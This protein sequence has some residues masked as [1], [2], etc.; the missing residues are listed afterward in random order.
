MTRVFGNDAVKFFSYVTRLDDRLLR[1]RY[2]FYT[3]Q[4]S[5][6][7]AGNT[8]CVFV[9]FCEVVGHARRARM[10]IPPAQ[11]FR[12][13]HFTRRSLHQ[14]RPPQENR[15][16]ILD[17]DGFIAH[18]RHVCT[19]CR[20]RAHDARDLWNSLGAQVRLVVEDAAKVFLVRKH[21]ILQGQES[22]AR[23][24]QINAGQVVLQ[25]H[26]LRA[27]VFFYRHRVI[28]AALYGGIVGDNHTFQTLDAADACDHAGGGGVSWVALILSCVL[29]I[30]SPSS[31]WRKLE[32]R[33]A[34]VEKRLYPIAWQQ[35]AA[36]D[37]F[38]V[39]LFA[40][41]FSDSCRVC[42]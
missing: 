6:D 35:L 12:G 28:G 32:E 13:H 36:C 26:F 33:R 9:I 19:A 17:D 3:V 22:T 30:H 27:Q 24:D 38:G 8:E 23:I 14:R 37:V 10:Y 42:I 31:E 41:T 4:V 20:A 7:F 21:F 29:A 1:H 34:W 5:H 18:R 39:R 11:F 2:F 25:C 40:A 16:L 15:A